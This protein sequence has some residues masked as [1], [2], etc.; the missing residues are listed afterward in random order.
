MY[1]NKGDNANNIFDGGISSDA[2]DFTSDEEEEK[3]IEIGDKI[4]GAPNFP[5]KVL[6]PPLFSKVAAI[7]G[8]NGK[9]STK[10]FKKSIPVSEKSSLPVRNV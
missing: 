10:S 7:S 4:E 1:R 6:A 8:D 5:G 2:N 3:E 9:I